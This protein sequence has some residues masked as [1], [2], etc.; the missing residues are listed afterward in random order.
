VANL[1]PDE[2]KKQQEVQRHVQGPS[3]FRSSEGETNDGRAGDAVR[4]IGSADRFVEEAV[5]SERRWCL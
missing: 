2:Q 4:S 3:G 5:G 1:V